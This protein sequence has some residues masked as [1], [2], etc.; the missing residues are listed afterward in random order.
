MER[1]VY[2]DAWFPRQHCYHPSLPP[3][4]LRMVDDLLDYRATVL[5]WSALG[6]GSLSLPYLEEEAFGR[7][8]PRSRFYGFVNDSEFIAEC[9][10]HGIKVF[11]IVFEA[12]GWEFPVELNESE[13]EILALNELRGSGRRDWL[14]LR[15]FSQNR[16]PKL[17]KPLES[18]FPGGLVNSDGEQVRDLIDE[19]VARDIHQQPCHAHWVECPDRDHECYYMDRNNPVWR[20]YLKAVIRIQIDAGVDGVQ[21]DEAELPMGAL[22]YGACFCKDCMKG[23]RTFLR[24]QPDRERDA[25]LSDVDLETFHYGEWLL[26]RGY[27]FKSDQHA[28]PLFGEYHQFQRAAVKEY[29]GE[30]AAYARQYGREQGREVL[31]SGNFFNLY[32][33]YYALVDDVD[34]VITEMRNTTYRQ[35]AWYRYVA[36]FAGAKEVVV[37]ENPYGGVVPEL[38]EKLSRGQGYDLFRLSLYEGAAMGANMTVPYG[39]WMG[40]RIE[41]AFYAPH[42]VASGIQDFLA[43]NEELYSRATYNEVAVAFSTES[44]SALIAAQDRSDNVVNA[45]DES[46]EVPFRI[47][48]AAFADAAVPFDVVML[49]DGAYA[50]DRLDVSDLRQY[51]TVVLPGCTWLTPGQVDAVRSYLDDGGQVVVV[52][53]FGTNLDAHEREKVVSHP[54]VR[55]AESRDVPAMLP[56]GRQVEAG[57]DLA[58]N[59]HRMADGG[60]AIH[61][62]NYGYDPDLDQV[63]PATDVD[64]RVRLPFA[65]TG[66]VLIR[67]GEKPVELGYTV[68]GGVHA[69]Q[70]D[71]AGLYSVVVARAG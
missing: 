34:L 66:V 3:R 40:S 39:A 43:E 30:L 21:L 24:M 67:P 23:F 1:G 71:E 16:Y 44:N 61:L 33:H 49:A 19:C 45:S 36:G 8:E 29:F 14:G 50:P 7:V 27:D 9:R 28:T 22:Q 15:E 53:E 59:I 20:E 12:Q 52:G 62:I 70:L 57:A 65:A 55:Q 5:V 31:V 47:V 58:V 41:D 48:T 69:V 26:E 60:A 17:W 25:L 4:R 38:V 6:G 13:D 11:G 56:A 2:F 42:E 37:V 63:V 46:V 64:L 51:A 68:A 18:Y 54:G 32:P 10:K 35:P